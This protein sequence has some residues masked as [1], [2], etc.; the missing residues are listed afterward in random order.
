MKIDRLIA[1][2]MFLLNRENVSAAALAGRFEVSKR[3]I[4]RDIET[5]SRAGIPIV[6][7]YGPEGGYGIVDGFKLTK[8]IA[9]LHDYLNIIIGLRGLVSAYESDRINQTL[10][11]VLASMR[12]GEQRIFID[13]TVAREDAQVNKTLQAIEKAIYGETLLKLEYTNSEGGS[14]SRIVEPLALSFQWYA[15]YLF[16]Y[17][18]EKRDYRTFKLQRITNCEPVSGVFSKAH[19]NIEE[20]MKS[21]AAS[22]KRKVY[23]ILLLCK[24]EIR[25]QALEYLRGRIA[26][27]CEN[28]DFILEMNVPLE[29][30]WFSL[31][32]GFGDSVKVLEPEE[33]KTMLKQRADKMLSIYRTQ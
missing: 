24:K 13:F 20:L 11:K 5:L 33:V 19:E 1:I 29:R 10:D 14:L 12:G 15:W 30:M 28:G 8:Q 3:T 32:M 6:S 18:T 7:T 2:T 16:A 27:E 4:Q 21:A 26:E 9:G 17:C 31:L 25:V 23:H 22:D